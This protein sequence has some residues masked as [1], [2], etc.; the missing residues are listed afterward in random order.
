[1]EIVLNKQQRDFLEKIQLLAIQDSKFNGPWH[2]IDNILKAGVYY[3]DKSSYYT[4]PQNAN[5]D[6]DKRSL[7]VVAE[8]YKN[9]TLTKL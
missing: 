8:R 4:P 7:N 3:D 9:K 6:N 5:Q 2:R 1:M